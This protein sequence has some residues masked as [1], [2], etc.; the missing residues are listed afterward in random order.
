MQR[1]LRLDSFPASKRLGVA[2]FAL[3]GLILATSFF[4]MTQYEEFHFVEFEIASFAMLL[5]KGVQPYQ[6]LFTELIPIGFYTPLCYLVPAA[7]G[8]LLGTVEPP[9]YFLLTFRMIVFVYLS[10]SVFLLYRLI[11]NWTRQRNLAL[12]I[13]SVLLTAPWCV[14]SARPD[15]QAF[16]YSLLA[17][18]FIL[19]RPLTL[20]RCFLIGLILAFAFLHCQRYVSLFAGCTLYLFSRREFRQAFTL[21]AAFLIMN[22]LVLAPLYVYTDGKILT[23]TFFIPSLMSTPTGGFQDNFKAAGFP[24]SILL[25]MAIYALIHLRRPPHQESSRLLRIY[26]LT[27]LFFTLCTLHLRGAAGNQLLELVLALS[28][29]TA[30]FVGLHPNRLASGLCMLMLLFFPLLNGFQAIRFWRAEWL[31][32]RGSYDL[33]RGYEKELEALIPGPLL[34]DD[35][36]IAFKTHHPEASIESWY[37]T[38]VLIPKELFDKRSI[39]QRIRNL[40]YSSIVLRAP[41]H[42]YET[43]KDEIEQHYRLA[44]RIGVYQVWR[45][46]AKIPP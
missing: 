28:L 4:Q 25:G 11:E 7:V 12:L 27:C 2:L 26:T 10:G 24:F 21:M 29:S 41:F 38:D 22:V 13:P 5:G 6:D 42:L 20:K 35:P 30:V 18:G 44:Q 19:R 39:V 9:F 40:Y 37:Y 45:K 15:W 33:S 3:L 31:G 32:T 36:A 46:P 43:F 1:F 34:T 14:L 16:F 8:R 17:L 23:H